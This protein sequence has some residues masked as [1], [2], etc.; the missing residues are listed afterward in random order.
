MATKVPALG[1]TYKLARNTGLAPAHWRAAGGGAVTPL[2]GIGA[3][4]RAAALR[5]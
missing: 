3:I 5:E 2:V 1:I 4:H